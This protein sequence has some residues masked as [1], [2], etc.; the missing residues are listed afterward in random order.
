LR[1][2]AS[3]EPHHHRK[4]Q[5]LGLVDGQERDAALGCVLG[6]VLVLADAAIDEE[7]QELV[8]QVAQVL[9]QP[10]GLSTLT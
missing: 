8:E 5:P 9:F 6:F 10:L 7:A 2:T 1:G 4:L 3:S